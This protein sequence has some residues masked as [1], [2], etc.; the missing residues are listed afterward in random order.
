VR[1]R[2][3][4]ALL[5]LAAATPAQDASLSDLAAER[6]DAT[7]L[8]DE[9]LY[10]SGRAEIERAVPLLDGPE[11]ARG[12]ARSRLRR[13][14][15]HLGAVQD[16]GRFADAADW[17][18]H[19]RWLR[20]DD[21]T[22]LAD[23]ERLAGAG[24]AYAA[25]L[26]GRLA[27][28]RDEPAVAW[29]ERAAALQPDDVRFVLD[30]AD[31]RAAEGDPEGALSA[32]DTARALG[33]E[34]AAWLATLLSTLSGRE[35]AARL[36][37]RLDPLLQEP[38]GALD[39]LLAWHRAWALE[40]L[41][42]TAEAEAVLAAATRGRTPDIERAQARLALLLGRPAAAAS[43]LGPLAEAG[44]VEALDLLVSAA[45]TLASGYRWDEALAI[46]AQALQAEPAHLR[47]AANR[48]LTLARS[49]RS[50]DGYRELLS[51]RPGRLDL[52][53]DAAL[54]ALGWG[55]TAEAREL[56]E[57]A[58]AGPDEAPGVADARENLAALLL[59]L[60]PP[61]AGA[62]LTLLDGVLAADPARDRSLSLRAAARR[63]S[64]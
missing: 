10:W 28:D 35:N 54:A 46:Y 37:A 36:L 12:L 25:W 60:R 56:L 15:E 47:A 24:S 53:N 21:E 14:E 22:L 34:R 2:L 48:A 18:L 39:A 57:R 50:L 38:E 13:A 27:R 43:T 32:L 9:A 17:V 26:R 44:D 64:R 16:A 61:E 29:F 3:A 23:L 33:A 55:R 58:A 11:F 42:R 20:G 51:A 40:Q 31:A 63:L 8:D 59:A 30:L 1:A 7:P 4:A 62:A 49:G 19:A 5:L 52:V 45:D 41:G 6:L